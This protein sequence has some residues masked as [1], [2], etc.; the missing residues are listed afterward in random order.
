M[1]FIAENLWY[2]D[3]K[4]VA[5][6]CQDADHNVHIVPKCPVSYRE[7]YAEL[8]SF[9]KFYTYMLRKR[10]ETC[11]QGEAIALTYIYTKMRLTNTPMKEFLRGY[12]ALKSL[13][14]T[15]ETSLILK[16]MSKNSEK[17]NYIEDGRT[18]KLFLESSR[19]L[20]NLKPAQFYKMECNLARYFLSKHQ[21]SLAYLYAKEAL[22]MASRSASS[23]GIEESRN[24]L[25][26]IERKL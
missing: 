12:C 10:E 9:H 17:P 5:D 19:Y 13:S 1:E 15:G 6:V 24:L 20:S 21:L 7:I 3:N 23:V 8:N 16:K 2:I 18:E 25:V 14:S 22:E 4:M 26:E 11:D